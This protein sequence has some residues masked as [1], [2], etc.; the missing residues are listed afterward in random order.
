MTGILNICLKLIQSKMVYTV[1]IAGAQG[2]R[3]DSCWLR[4]SCNCDNMR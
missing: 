2:N 4:L 3:R 1:E